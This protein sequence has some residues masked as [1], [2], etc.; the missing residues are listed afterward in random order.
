MD[1]QGPGH[2]ACF[3]FG[4]RGGLIK[5]TNKQAELATIDWM[6]EKVDGKC[7]RLQLVGQE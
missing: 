7:V 5:Q 4:D 3:L 1:A 6:V 2:Q